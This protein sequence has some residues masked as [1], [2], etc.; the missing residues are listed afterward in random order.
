[1]EVAVVK[2]EKDK[3]ELDPADLY[4]PP[5]KLAEAIQ[6]PIDGRWVNRVLNAYR[7]T[8]KVAP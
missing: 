2:V 3:V 8:K 7:Q 6:Y 4:V 1:M 5:N